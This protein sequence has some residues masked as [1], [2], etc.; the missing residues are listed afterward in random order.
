MRRTVL[1]RLAAL[2]LCLPLLTGCTLLHFADP[3]EVKADEQSLG[4]EPAPAP[5]FA[6]RLDETR[7]RFEETCTDADGAVVARC[8]AALPWFRG[9]EQAVRNVDAHYEEELEALRQDKDSLFALALEKPADT[10]RE[11]ATGFRL[12][13]APEGYV[14]V[15]GTIDS[16][17]ALGR[18]PTRWFGDVFSAATGW[19][20]RFDDL[21]GAQREQALAALTEAAEAWCAEHGCETSWLEEALSSDELTFDRETVYIGLPAGLAPGGE[22]LL[23]LP[24]AC[25]ADLLQ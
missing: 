14:C 2:A 7:L 18:S 23:E 8:S 19:P 16:V 25:I 13:D 10:V 3:D 21:F 4:A 1:M 15:L 5:D 20:L 9:E 17:D 24:F 6:A 12:L 11:S 22:T